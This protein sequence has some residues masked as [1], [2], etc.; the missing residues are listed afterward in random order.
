[1]KDYNETLK[2]TIGVLPIQIN[3]HDTS[4]SDMSYYYKITIM[5]IPKALMKDKGRLVID[6]ANYLF[7]CG[8]RFESMPEYGH[9]DFKANSLTFYMTRNHAKDSINGTFLK[10]FLK[11]EE[12]MLKTECFPMV[13]GVYLAND[14]KGE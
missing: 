3:T 4:S 10:D 12:W 13:Y 11:A 2:E 5:D 14:P 6:A 7:R 1:M 9:R 8:L